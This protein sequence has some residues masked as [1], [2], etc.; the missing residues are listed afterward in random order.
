MVTRLTLAIAT[1]VDPGILIIDE[2]L[3]AG[4]VLR[5]EDLSYGTDSTCL[6]LLRT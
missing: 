4:D 3:G 6:I 1:A 5:N 2:G